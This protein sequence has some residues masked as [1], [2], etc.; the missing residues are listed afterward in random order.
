MVY[1]DFLHKPG[2]DRF[3]NPNNIPLNKWIGV[4][5]VVTKTSRNSIYIRLF[6]DNGGGW[7]LAAEAVDDGKSFGG[8]VIGSSGR[9]GIR[10]DFMDVDIRDYMVK[11]A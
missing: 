3:R 1:K 6:I 2:Y 10:T 8:P 7:V 9:L 5:T 11:N 4:K